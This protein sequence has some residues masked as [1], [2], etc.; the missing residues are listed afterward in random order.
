MP[1]AVST[2]RRCPTWYSPDGVIPVLMRCCVWVCRSCWAT[3]SAECC[4]RG[5]LMCLYPCLPLPREI[6]HT[7]HTNYAG[8]ALLSQSCCI[9]A[10]FYGVTRGKTRETASSRTAALLPA[11]LWLFEPDAPGC[12]RQVRQRSVA[13]CN[14]QA[15][16]GHGGL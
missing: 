4:G 8:L 2:S 11:C 1:A 7:V 16:H 6:N 15:R 3:A 5:S 14:N 10:I 12:L 13:W 9:K